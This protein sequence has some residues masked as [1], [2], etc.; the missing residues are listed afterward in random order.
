MWALSGTKA[1]Q[2]GVAGFKAADKFRGHKLPRKSFADNVAIF[3][4]GPDNFISWVHV[5]LQV[6]D[7][8]CSA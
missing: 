5:V 4:I 8:Y 6:V 3:G 1:R 2:I 7:G